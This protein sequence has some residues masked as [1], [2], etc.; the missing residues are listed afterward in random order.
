MLFLHTL[1]HF[2][3][4]GI[5]GAVLAAYAVN[6]SYFEPIA[7]YF[8][9]YN[10]I[11][12]GSQWL[13]GYLLDRKFNLIGHAFLVSLITLA[14]GTISEL[15]ILCQTILLGIGNSLFHVAGGSL[16]L[17]KY[18][19]YKEL[20]I[21]VSSGAIG[22]ALGLNLLCNA[23][24]F[25]LFYAAITLIVFYRLRRGHVDIEV[26]SEAIDNKY[27][28]FPLIAM[29][30]CIILLLG[31]VV[32]RGF[33]GGNSVSD[34]VM[35]FPCVFA[36]GKVLGGICCD[37]IGYKNTIILIFLLSFLSLQWKGLIPIV[38]LTLAFNMTMP[39]TLR[40]VHFCN[41]NYPGM[42]FGLAAGCLLPGAFFHNDFSVIPQAMV[43]I[44]FLTLFIAGWLFKTYNQRQ[45]VL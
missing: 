7:Y 27:V 24:V 15:G 1:Q 5:C 14:L 30:G 26:Q 44:Q 16:V 28:G 25:L 12:F 17:R 20:G 32:L 18:K 39:L 29:L 22:L 2:T 8:G 38:I 37:K 3:V 23:I 21:F 40:L 36:A 34:Y 10:L 45:V 13:I 41:P 43:V 42:M 9:L 6:E 11:A 33:G 19:T 4:D 31:C 35:L